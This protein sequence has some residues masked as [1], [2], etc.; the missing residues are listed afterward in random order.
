MHFSYKFMYFY[1]IIYGISNFVTEI[2]ISECTFSSWHML[3]RHLL[4]VRGMG[5]SMQSRCMCL[6][7]L[8]HSTILPSLWPHSIQHTSPVA[9]N[10][11]L[12]SHVISTNRSFLHNGR[13]NKNVLRVAHLHHMILVPYQSNDKELTTTPDNIL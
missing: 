2:F 8:S 9:W 10:N 12:H 6:G 5:G 4:G 13:N 1:A 7:H 11:Q 3:Q